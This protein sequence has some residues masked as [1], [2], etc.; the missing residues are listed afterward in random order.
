MST[1]KPGYKTTE[2]WLTIAA[3][4]IGLVWASGAVSHG[5]SVDKILGLCAMVMSQ[6]GYTVSRG[7]AKGREPNV[8]EAPKA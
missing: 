3:Q 1:S 8:V 7:L 6:L 5:G 2:F 4:I